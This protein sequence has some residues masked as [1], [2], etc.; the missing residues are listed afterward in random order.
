MSVESIPNPEEIIFKKFQKIRR[1]T[2]DR[3]AIDFPNLFGTVAAAG[4]CT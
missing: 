4:N 1:H 2:E 3:G